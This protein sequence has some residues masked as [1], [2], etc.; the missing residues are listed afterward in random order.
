MQ[1]S[2]SSS[3]EAAIAAGVLKTSAN[4][5]AAAL[6][7]AAKDAE[8]MCATHPAPR[9][10]HT[11]SRI[12]HPACCAAPRRTPCCV[13]NSDK[14]IEKLTKQLTNVKVKAEPKIVGLYGNTD[15]TIVR[16]VYEGTGTGVEKSYFTKNPGGSK[17]YLKESDADNWVVMDEDT[18]NARVA[19][20]E[21]KMAALKNS[22]PAK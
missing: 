15:G 19:A 22:S 9:T 14:E 3:E 16:E 5:A 7:T 1:P 4:A 13:S 17:R 20:H 11:T 12:S 8:S 6:N 2:R 10:P 21:A 18:V